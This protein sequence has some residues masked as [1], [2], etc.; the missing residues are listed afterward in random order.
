MQ[1]SL[2]TTEFKP[3]GVNKTELVGTPFSRQKWHTMEPDIRMLTGRSFEQPSITSCTLKS[4]QGNA[5]KTQED[6]DCIGHRD[7]TIYIKYQINRE[8]WQKTSTIYYLAKLL[9][10]FDIHNKTNTVTAD[11]QSGLRIIT[12]ARS[13]STA[14]VAAAVSIISGRWRR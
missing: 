8:I 6:I 13:M 5:S 10:F 4:V 14:T 1:F 12:G 3:H 2:Q 9:S 7:R 11:I